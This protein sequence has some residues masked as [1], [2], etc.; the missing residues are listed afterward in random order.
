MKKTFTLNP[1]TAKWTTKR[2]TEE[3][4]EPS[5]KSDDSDGINYKRGGLPQRKSKFKN[6]L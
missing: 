3:M 1:N 6:I 5:S 4:K 2:N